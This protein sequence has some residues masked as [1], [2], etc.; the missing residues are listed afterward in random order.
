MAGAP[1]RRKTLDEVGL[2]PGCEQF[3][4]R[5]IKP[6]RSQH[7]R[8]PDEQFRAALVGQN[9]DALQ[10][11]VLDEHLQENGNIV[12]A[13]YGKVFERPPDDLILRISKQFAERWGD[14]D[15]PAPIVKYGHV[16][17]LNGR[18][19]LG[20]KSGQPICWKDSKNRFR[21]GHKD[22]GANLSLMITLSQYMF[23]MTLSQIMQLDKRWPRRLSASLPCP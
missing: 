7:R 6:V 19:V 9:P 15:E 8:V 5:F 13:G 23:C 22:P 11:S 2:G 20:R 4:R 14:F 10:I 12:C 1:R 21:M 16:V 18:A 3:D 17:W